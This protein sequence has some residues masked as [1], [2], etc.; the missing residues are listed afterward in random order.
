MLLCDRTRPVLLVG[1][2]ELPRCNRTPRPGTTGMAAEPQVNGTN[3]N[4]SRSFYF[5]AR[6]ITEHPENVFKEK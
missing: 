5:S 2:A 1:K 4:N 6:E 3:K